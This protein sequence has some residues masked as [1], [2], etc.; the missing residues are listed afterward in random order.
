M[1]DI[2]AVVGT[3]A[4]LLSLAGV[5]YAFGFWRGKV[6]KQL[7]DLKDAHIPKRLDKMEAKQE[8]LW[9]VFT[10]QVLSNRPNLAM[11][12]SQFKLTGEA[13]KAIEEVNGLIADHNPGATKVTSEHIL[14]DLPAEIG[15]ENL[16]DIAE[17][18]SM[19]LGELL[20]IISVALGIDI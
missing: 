2:L 9:T 8:V 4:G 16:K 11:K 14:C 12:G 13:M 7:S 10:E 15:L 17:R 5:V 19:T 1:N 18:H 20:A 6:D 3:I